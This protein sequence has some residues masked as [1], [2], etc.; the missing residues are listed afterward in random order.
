M[1]TAETILVGGLF[2]SAIVGT[3]WK[4]W[5]E[6]AEVACR[7]D[8]DVLESLRCAPASLTASA[9]KWGTIVVGAITGVALVVSIAGQVGDDD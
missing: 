7:A 8:A 4:A 5:A 3:L 9:F 1:K 6:P 2:G